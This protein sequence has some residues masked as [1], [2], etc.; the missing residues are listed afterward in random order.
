MQTDRISSIALPAALFLTAMP[1]PGPASP[2][3]SDASE[4]RLPEVTGPYGVGTLVWHWQQREAS[5]DELLEVMAQLWYPTSV[6]GGDHAR[7]RPLGGESFDRI[8]QSS[9]GAAPFAS[10]PD[11]APVVVVCPG[12]GT[13]RYYYTSIAEELSSQGFAVLAV[14][15]PQIGDVEFPDGRIVEPSG[16]FRP[17]FELITGPYEK[18]DAFFETAVSIGMKHLRLALKN[19]AELNDNDPAGI[20]TARLNLR[21]IGAFG[22]SLGG[23]LC[24]AL[25]GRDPRVVA[26]AAMEGV[27]PRKERQ[28]G[29]AAASL[30]L[31]SSE[32]PED[33]A[34]PN[35]RELFDNRKA[36][37]TI[38][39]LEGF[40]HNS[41]T[42]LPLIDP[43][44]FDYEIDPRDAID[45]MR[46]ILT[47]FFV[48]HLMDGSFSPVDIA[49]AAEV[50]LI[51]TSIESSSPGP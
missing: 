21:T 12:R 16:Q 42:D 22:H 2:V 6:V 13:N 5:D 28:Q 24:G 51:G 25:A 14:D 35:I 43:D 46:G 48:A 36:E 44:N 7:Y 34:L 3:P 4:I 30:M 29:I 15:I 31:Y 32:L 47:D 26:L 37:A 39:R 41:V 10:L 45:I 40:G 18:V 33:M 17:S 20:V 8:R 23:R 49:K 27:P 38:L 11:E 9:I 1:L 50:T 19:L